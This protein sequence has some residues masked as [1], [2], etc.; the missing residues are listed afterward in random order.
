MDQWM[1]MSVV[2]V[3]NLTQK[4]E[5]KLNT[6]MMILRF[7]ITLNIS[8]G[9]IKYCRKENNIIIVFLFFKTDEESR[10]ESKKKVQK[11]CQ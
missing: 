9:S 4:I 1:K 6:K 10:T 8:R 11:K 3:T 5:E 2:K 7:V